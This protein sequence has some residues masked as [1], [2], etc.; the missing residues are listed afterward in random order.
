[1][2]VRIICINKSD[3]YDPH[4]RIRAVGGVNPDGKRWKLSLDQAVEGALAE[5][6]DFFVVRGGSEVEVVVARSAAGNLYLKTEAD[7]ETPNNLL[8]LPE[9]P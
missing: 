2:R 8:S 9:C 5:K 3:R 6:Y 1:M 4:E 7:G